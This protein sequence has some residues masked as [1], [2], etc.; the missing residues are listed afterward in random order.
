MKKMPFLF[1]NGPNYMLRGFKMLG[2]LIVT[3]IL[4]ATMIIM[5]FEV[6]NVLHYDI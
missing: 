6:R 2:P 1:L 5:I 4:F 3:M